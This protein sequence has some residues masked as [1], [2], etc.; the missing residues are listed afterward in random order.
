MRSE[1]EIKNKIV[2]YGMVIKSGIR[3][4][5]YHQ[6]MLRKQIRELKW[7]LGEGSDI[8]LSDE[9]DRQKKIA[10]KLEDAVSDDYEN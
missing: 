4:D 3:L 6:A 5:T 9:F 1:D 2:H 7:V 8:S 10:V